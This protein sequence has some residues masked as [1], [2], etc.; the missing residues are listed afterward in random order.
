LFVA[1]GNLRNA[2]YTQASCPS[3]CERSNV[4]FVN[5]GAN[6]ALNAAVKTAFKGLRR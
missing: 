3:F 6:G 4:Q 1:S 2:G 5:W